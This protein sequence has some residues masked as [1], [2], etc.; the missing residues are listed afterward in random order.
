[1]T[2]VDSTRATIGGLDLCFGRWDLHDHP[3]ADVHV[4][5]FDDTLYPGRTFSFFQ[6]LLDRKDVFVNFG[7][8]VWV[9]LQRITTT[10]CVFLSFCEE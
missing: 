6:S 1:M 10:V 9:G 8:L 5:K 7:P 2:I 3:L 4:T